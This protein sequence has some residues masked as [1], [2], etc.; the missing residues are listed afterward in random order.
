MIHPNEKYQNLYI[1][2]NI[3]S[4]NIFKMC[5]FLLLFFFIESMNRLSIAR[6]LNFYMR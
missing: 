3:D 4:Y 2:Q 6:D 1:V 5:L